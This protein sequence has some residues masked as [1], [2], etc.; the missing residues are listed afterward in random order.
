[1]AVERAGSTAR[2]RLVAAAPARAD[3][4]IALRDAGRAGA[5]VELR[6][7]G[8]SPVAGESHEGAVAYPGA[9][10]DADVVVVLEAERVEEFRI[11]RSLRRA[12]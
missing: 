3:G 2:R 8:R 7:H 12:A 10:R 1:V 6:P 9:E 4:A 11:L 5:W